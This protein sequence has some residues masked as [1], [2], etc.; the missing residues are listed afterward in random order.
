MTLSYNQFM[1]TRASKPVTVTLGELAEVAQARVAT[2]RYASL[3]EVVR[4]GLRALDRE[5]AALDDLIRARIAE[6]NAAPADR[7][8]LA[9]GM[10]QLRAR[11]SRPV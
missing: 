11:L 2:G 7:V 3:S 6:V 10:A 1:A 8:A 4:A 9:D 5:E